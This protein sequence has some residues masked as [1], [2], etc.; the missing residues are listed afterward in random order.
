MSLL[1]SIGEGMW[2]ETGYRT[3]YKE[4]G[5]RLV[6]APEVPEHRMPT[7]GPRDI[8]VPTLEYVGEQHIGGWVV[9]ADV[10]GDG[11]PHQATDETPTETEINS[12]TKDNMVDQRITYIGDAANVLGEQMPGVTVDW[13]KIH[14]PAV[15]SKEGK[16]T[17]RPSH[18][19]HHS[20]GTVT[21]ETEPDPNTGEETSMAYRSNVRQIIFKPCKKHPIHG[22]EM[23]PP[24]PIPTSPPAPLEP[25][26][27]TDVAARPAPQ[28]TVDEE[29]RRFARSMFDDA[30]DYDA[31]PGPITHD[32]V[33]DLENKYKRQLST[34]PYARLYLNV[35]DY[36]LEEYEVTPAAKRELQS[37]LKHHEWHGQSMNT[38]VHPDENTAEEAMEAN[39]AEAGKEVYFDVARDI[40]YFGG[41]GANAVT[42]KKDV[43]CKPMDFA[44]F[45]GF[46]H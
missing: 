32:M 19:V 6:P 3:A 20:D 39:E 15:A 22:C 7:V 44:C 38:Y 1:K 8:M 13:S 41:S 34:K 40:S 24:M 12:V 26:V 21:Q 28:F 5:E 4:D 9:T 14:D 45:F 29:G 2:G 35:L 11:M 27:V 37:Y 23:D 46:S 33:E 36:M 17:T 18:I 10:F 30:A 42:K 43:M 31:E 25:M 16:P